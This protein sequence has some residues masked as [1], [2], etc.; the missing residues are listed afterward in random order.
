MVERTADGHNL[1]IQRLVREGTANVSVDINRQ[2][3]DHRE[4]VA[5]LLLWLGSAALR[6]RGGGKRILALRGAFLCDLRLQHE[7]VADNSDKRRKTEDLKFRETGDESDGNQHDRTQQN[8]LGLRKELVDD[9]LSERL[10]V[11]I[12]NTRDDNAGRDR[13]EKRRN[14]RN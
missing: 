14:L 10:V 11:N 6:R 2:R 7:A 13:D 1:L 9:V 3:R 8:C 4:V 5:F 12:A